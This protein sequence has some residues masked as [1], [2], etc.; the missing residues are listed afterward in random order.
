MLAGF[1]LTKLF[2]MPDWATPAIAFN[3]TTSLPLLLVQSLETTGILA[4]I[5]NSGDAVNRAKSYFLLNSMIGNTLTFALGPRLLNGHEEDA[6]H[7]WKDEDGHED[8][9]DDQDGNIEAQE[10]ESE[11]VNERTSLLPNR[12][13][14]DWTRAEYRGYRTGKRYWKELPPWGRHVLIFLYSFLNPATIGAVIGILLGLVPPLHRL[15]FNDQYHGGYLNGWLT[16]ATQNIGDLFA[17]LQVVVVGVKLS[18]ALVRMKNG[19]A[20]GRVPWLP[21]I[22]ITLIRFVIWPAISIPIIYVL[23]SK[24]NLLS[25]DPIVWFTM[26]L[27]PV[28]P[29]ALKLTALADVN[30]AD[31]DERMSIAKF[32]TVLNSLRSKFFLADFYRRSLILYRL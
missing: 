3:N 31:D 24:T 4:A 22:L 23:A 29:P 26:M 19:E 7:E 20:S 2:G 10:E 12:I 1:A 25:N 28:G 32:L 13:T 8:N 11:Q 9:T 6:P 5:D 27:M 30:G 21:M 18:N 17:S 14:R 15:F 16:S